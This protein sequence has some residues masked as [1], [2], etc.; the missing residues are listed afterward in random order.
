MI[1]AIASMTASVVPQADDFLAAEP[2]PIETLIGQR[3][4]MQSGL[5]ASNSLFVVAGPQERAR[6]E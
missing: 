1:G 2:E 4:Y 5:N 6:W 3:P